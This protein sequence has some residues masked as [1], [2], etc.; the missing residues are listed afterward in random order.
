MVKINIHKA[1]YDDLEEILELQKSAYVSEAGLYSEIVIPPMKQSLSEIQEEYED[2]HFYKLVIDSSIIGSVRV[3]H[4][5][6]TC[7]IN[8]LCVHPQ[9]QGQGF[10][11]LLMEEA[12]RRAVTCRRFELFTGHRSARN[13]NFYKNLGYREFKEE[14]VNDFLTLIYMDK[15]KD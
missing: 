11:R 2:N 14:I 4:S 9:Y 8:K 6:D 13:R 5:H 10:G 12:E 3:R 1:S 7:Y 15:V